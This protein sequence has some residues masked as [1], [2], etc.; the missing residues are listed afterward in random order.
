M[1][2]QSDPFANTDFPTDPTTKPILSPVLPNAGHS[3][4]PAKL[5]RGQVR[6]IAADIAAAHGAVIVET[7]GTLELRLEARMGHV[8]VR[9]STSLPEVINIPMYADKPGTATVMQIGQD[10]RAAFK[11]ARRAA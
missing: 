2:T 10:L 6:S 11:N 4:A 9:P 1:P 3:T 5:T 8:I 7:N